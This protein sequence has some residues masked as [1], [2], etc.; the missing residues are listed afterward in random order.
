MPLNQ[1]EANNLARE[2]ERIKGELTWC[3]TMLV[4]I[5]ARIAGGAQ[6]LATMTK[7][8]QDLGIV[9]AKIQSETVDTP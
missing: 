8:H 1:G 7:V 4:H 2:I 3:N 9:I 5:P 6:T